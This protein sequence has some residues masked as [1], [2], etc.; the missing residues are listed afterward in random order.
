MSWQAIA[1]ST[2]RASAIGAALAVA[3]LSSGCALQARSDSDPKASLAQCHNY[4]FAPTVSEHAE[5][6]FANPL[7]DKRLRDAIGT[8]LQSRGMRV[9]AGGEA[10]DCLVNY[11]IGSRVGVEPGTPRTSWGFGWGWGRRGYGGSLGYDVPYDYREGRVSVDLSD[12]RT[13]DALWHAYVN[14]DVT[15]LMGEQAER[16]IQ[17]VVAAIFARFPVAAGTK[18]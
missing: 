2:T 1:A 4:G 11:A 5:G 3:V 12:A 9:A 10:V 16:R 14:A 18:M 15:N 8:Q 7:N 13:H 6:A 17:E